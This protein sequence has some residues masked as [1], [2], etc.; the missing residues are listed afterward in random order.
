M[1]AVALSLGARLFAII[2][3]R[4]ETANTQ[5]EAF[6]RKAFN[7]INDAELGR[8]RRGYRSNFSPS[9]NV[10]TLL[11]CPLLVCSVSASSNQGG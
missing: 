3:C 1:Y 10:K 4:I 9:N 6:S 7:A 8:R 5:H 11:S 2:R